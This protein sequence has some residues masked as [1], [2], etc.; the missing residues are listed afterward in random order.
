M[1]TSHNNGDSTSDT[2][3][4]ITGTGEPGALVTV[5]DGNGHTCTDTVDASGNWSC[6]ISPAHNDGD[7][8]TYIVSQVDDAG[9]VSPTDSVSITIDTTAPTAPTVDNQLSNSTTPTLT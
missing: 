5:D 2:T 8:P 1:I 7:T 3:P 4:T 6:N 9:N